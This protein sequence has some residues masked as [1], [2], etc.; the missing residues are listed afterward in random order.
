MDSWQLP[1]GRANCVFLYSVSF[2]YRDSRSYGGRKAPVGSDTKPEPGPYHIVA[3]C[4]QNAL[5]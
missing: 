4:F 5:A 2:R 3:T 1:L